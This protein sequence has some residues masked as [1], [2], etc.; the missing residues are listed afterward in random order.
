MILESKEKR[1]RRLRDQPFP[2]AWAELLRLRFPL[3][4]R[5]REDDRRELEG[6]IRVFLDE[7]YIEGCEGLEITEEIRLLIAAQACLLL[8]HRD[9]DYYPDLRSI[10][11]YPS[12]Y[13]S[14]CQQD[15]EEGQEEGCL[16]Q[17]WLRGP[18]ILAWDAVLHGLHSPDDG[19]NVA[20]HEFAHQL[21]TEDGRADGAPLLAPGQPR[22]E[23]VLRY[24]SWARVLA[25]DFEDL[26]ESCQAG[27]R[28]LLN[29][30]GASHPAEF[31]AVVTEFF[32]EKPIP[33]R[34]K[35]PALYA[36]LSAF[37]RQDP[38]AWLALPPLS[39]SPSGP[40][41]VDKVNW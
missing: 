2:A 29:P 20:L 24:R 1:R 37:Y 22:S 33:L 6:H 41:V 34:E 27:S 7:K 26:Q 23:R 17:S 32:F 18:V 15:A 8:L 40:L 36:E 5:L 30:Y 13:F 14:Q 12:T 4:H 21:D 31:F 16:G 19:H 35:H 9:T 25:K 11:V 39:T 10:L 28:T 3:Y 38:A